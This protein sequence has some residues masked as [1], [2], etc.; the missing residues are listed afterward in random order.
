[1][2]GAAGALVAGEVVWGVW[3]ARRERQKEGNGRPTAAAGGGGLLG[4]DGSLE[5]G[6]LSEEQEH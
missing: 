3:Q 6:L 2:G 5:E 4:G 1:V